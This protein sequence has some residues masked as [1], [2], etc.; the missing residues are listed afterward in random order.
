MERGEKVRLFIMSAKI[1][2]RLV[3]KTI[4]WMMLALKIR[5]LLIILI[6]NIIQTLSLFLQMYN[7]EEKNLVLLVIRK[8]KSYSRFVHHFYN[9]KKKKKKK[10]KNLK[11]MQILL[12]YYFIYNCNYCFCRNKF[13]YYSKICHCKMSSFIY[14]FQHLAVFSSSPSRSRSS[15]LIQ[16]SCLLLFIYCCLFCL[17]LLP[18]LFN[19]SVFLLFLYFIP[20]LP[21]AKHLSYVFFV[22]DRQYQ[23]RQ[24]SCARNSKATSWTREKEEF[25]SVTVIM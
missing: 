22:T 11:M 16:F 4:H 5:M 19:C 24:V 17:F 7:L 1:K 21:S 20:T 15:S 18:R 6:F 13:V 25:V 3:I 9:M 14:I 23:M 12:D 10:K 8:L 2:R